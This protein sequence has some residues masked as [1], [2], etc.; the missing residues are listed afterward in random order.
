MTLLGGG[1]EVNSQTWRSDLTVSCPGLTAVV[2]CSVLLQTDKDKHF[3][4]S[5]SGKVGR[6]TVNAKAR[7]APAGSLDT[8][9]CRNPVLA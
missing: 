6:A 5:G 3:K 9:K 2:G 8:A 1:G 4:Q 7:R